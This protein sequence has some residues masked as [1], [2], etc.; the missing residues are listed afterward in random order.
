MQ[1]NDYIQIFLQKEL[2]K[3]GYQYIRKKMS[4]TEARTLLGQGFYQIDKREMA[5]A[6]ASCLF[7]PVIVRKGKEGLFE[8]PY[9]NSIF[10]SKNI[11]F[12]LSK[13]WLMRKVQY[14]ARGKPERAYAKWLVLHFIWKQ[15][16]KNINSGYPE[17]KFRYACEQ[18][19]SEVLSPLN[20]CLIYTYRAVLKF[21]RLNRGEGEE[22]KDPSTFF[23]RSKLNVEF[24]NFWDSNNNPY[25]SKVNNYIKKF[26]DALNEI[27]IEE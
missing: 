16:C 22:A 3:V 11:S 23:Q 5:Q 14:A 25:N 13:W 7:D 21:Y 27:N 6:V 17:K 4:K 1:A 8:D 9:Y 2:R 18:N 20:N 10:S 19:T 15:I 24:A 12:Y 26:M